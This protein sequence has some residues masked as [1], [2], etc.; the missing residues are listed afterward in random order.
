MKESPF[1]NVLDCATE[2]ETQKVMEQNFEP[3]SFVIE[4]R[5]WSS[6]SISSGGK[7]GCVAR[8]QSNRWRAKKRVG[9]SATWVPT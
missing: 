8:Y 5:C 7:S 6:L 9:G 2:C 4:I 3:L 1:R